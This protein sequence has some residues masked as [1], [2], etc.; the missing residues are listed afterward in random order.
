[1][2]PRMQVYFGTCSTAC[3]YPSCNACVRRCSTHICTHSCS[4]PNLYVCVC[5]FCVQEFIFDFQRMPTKIKVHRF[6]EGLASSAVLFKAVESDMVKGMFYT[7]ALLTVLHVSSHTHTYTHTD[8]DVV[9]VLFRFCNRCT[10]LPRLVNPTK[11][12]VWR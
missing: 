8:D 6:I 3:C 12:S 1:M 11:P 5:S 4:N 7:V 10:W 2:R 9:G